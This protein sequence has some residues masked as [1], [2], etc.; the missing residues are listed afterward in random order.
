[1]NDTHDVHGIIVSLT[2]WINDEPPDPFKLLPAMAVILGRVSARTASDKS[3]LRSL[4][5][6]AIN[7]MRVA[8]EE[9]WKTKHDN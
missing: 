9:D 3:E 8:A 5:D 6:G 7:V 2:K 4:L 1:M